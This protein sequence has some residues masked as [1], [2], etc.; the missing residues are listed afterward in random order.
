[1]KQRTNL[2]ST[3]KTFVVISTAFLFVFNSCQKDDQAQQKP[4]VKKL[5]C[6]PGYPFVDE[7]GRPIEYDGDTPSEFDCPSGTKVGGTLPEVQVYGSTTP[8]T[9]MDP[10]QSNIP[11]FYDFDQYSSDGG[12]TGT[13]A[14][15]GTGVEGYEEGGIS[16]EYNGERD[17][18]L[19]SNCASF[20]Y[21]PVAGGDYQVCGVT[22]LRFDFTT[23]WVNLKGQVQVDYFRATFDRTVYFEFP[24]MR[25]NDDMITARAAAILT[26]ELKDRAENALESQIENSPPPKN[27]VELELLF[28]RF[29][30]IL[31]YEMKTVG[32]RV[33]FKNNYNTTSIREYS[34]SIFGAGGC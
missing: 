25:D 9:L 7:Y 6:W 27:G 14:G 33:T 28:K 20:A 11:L 31:N 13:G 8:W 10:W 5:A 22:D 2:R 23:E 12:T 19:K 24:R 3:F 26:A 21:E 29:M 17:P 32:G 4:K 1:M 15:G 16:V 34:K 30:G 18:D